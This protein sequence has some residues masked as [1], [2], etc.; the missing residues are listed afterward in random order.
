MSARTTTGAVNIS[1]ETRL[2]ALSAA[3]EKASSCYQTNVPVKV[4]GKEVAFEKK[5]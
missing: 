3:A 5:K 4:S 2:A 1:A